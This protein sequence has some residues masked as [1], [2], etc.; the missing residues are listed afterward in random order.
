MLELHQAAT[1]APGRAGVSLEDLPVEGHTCKL[2]GLWAILGILIP[3]G[4]FLFHWSEG[5]HIAHPH[6]G[7]AGGIIRR[8]ISGGRGHWGA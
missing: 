8:R 3:E 5:N 7:R 2:M 4:H 1:R 6:W